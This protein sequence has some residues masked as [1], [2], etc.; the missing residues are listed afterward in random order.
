MNPE[1]PTRRKLVVALVL[2]AG[3]ASAPAP[4]LLVSGAWTR[5]GGAGMNG[6]G[7]LTIANRGPIADRLIAAASPVA[8]KVSLHQSREV[9]AMMTMRPVAFIEVGA[10]A[11]VTL[12]PGGLHLMLEGLRRPLRTGQSVPVTLIFARAGQVRASLVV[13]G[14]APATP[15]MAM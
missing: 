3:G 1:P 15:G 6:A 11:R 12:A 4:R 7:Y 9:G 10:A 13:R 2:L 14:G 8:G 5:P